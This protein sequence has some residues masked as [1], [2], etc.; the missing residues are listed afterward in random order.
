MVAVKTE[1]ECYLVHM[2]VCLYTLYC[3][4]MGIPHL[5]DVVVVE[6]PLKKLLSSFTRKTQ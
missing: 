2:F 5:L 6:L 3:I 1:L 4:I